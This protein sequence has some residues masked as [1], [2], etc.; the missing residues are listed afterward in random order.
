MTFSRMGPVVELGVVLLSEAVYQKFRPFVNE[1]THDLILNEI[2]DGA[3]RL[4]QINR[5]VATEVSEKTNS[6]IWL[7]GGD[8][9]DWN[10]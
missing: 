10:R 4:M 7:A 8:S 6:F 9:T 2:R 1:E 5:L 3:P